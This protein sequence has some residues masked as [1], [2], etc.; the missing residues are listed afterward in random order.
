MGGDDTKTYQQPE[1]RETERFWTKI[2]QPKNNEKTEWIINMTKELE[3]LEENP[4]AKIHINLLKMTQK[5]IKLENARPS[6][7]VQEIHLHSRKTGARNDQMPTR[8]TRT[9]MDE[10]RKDHMAPEGPK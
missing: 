6:F 1:T 2:W 9:R 4:K 10:Q 7:L 3:G 8:S 5:Y